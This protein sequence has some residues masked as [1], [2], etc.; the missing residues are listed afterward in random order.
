M[1]GPGKQRG[2]KVYYLQPLCIEVDDEL[3]FTT[4]DLLKSAI[5][6]IQ[7]EVFAE[8]RRRYWGHRARRFTLAA[9]DASLAIPRA[10]LKRGLER[11]KREITDYQAKLEFNRRK[12]AHRAAALYRQCRSEGCT[13]DEMLSLTNAPGSEDVIEQYAKEKQ[14]SRR[15][16]EMFLLATAITLP[17]FVTL[18]L[19][20]YAMASAIVTVTAP[21]A[22][23]DPAFV[24]EMPDSPGVLLKIGHFD[25]IR[26]VM[27][28]EI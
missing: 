21:V 23:C 14:L 9:V 6:K 27:H 5:E 24:A 2:V 1:D 19:G 22:V 28:V 8:Y 15:Q 7:T 4:R 10:L 20:I 17:W 11:R 18:A 12:T 26:G 25:K 13:Y 16:K 3:I